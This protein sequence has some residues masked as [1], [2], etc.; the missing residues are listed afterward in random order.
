MNKNEFLTILNQCIE[1][2]ELEIGLK[3]ESGS[4]NRCFQLYPIIDI[5]NPNTSETYQY[6][7]KGRKVSIS[8]LQ[9]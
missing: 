6:E 4:D 9:K 2:G 1:D 7:F 8:I 5:Y 3:A